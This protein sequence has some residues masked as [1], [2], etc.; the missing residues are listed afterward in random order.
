LVERDTLHRRRLIEQE[1]RHA[2]F[3]HGNRFLHF[4]NLFN[5]HR[6]LN[7]GLWFSGLRARG[8][9]NALDIQVTQNTFSFPHLPPAFDGCRILHLSDLHINGHGRIIDRIIEIISALE[10]DLCVLTGDYRFHLGRHCT[11]TYHKNLSRVCR[12]INSRLG[13][14]A[15]LG[16]HDLLEDVTT[17]TALG[18]TVL[19]NENCGVEDGGDVLWVAGVDDPHYYRCAN[20]PRAL[21]GIPDDVFTLLLAHTPSIYDEAAAAGID[22]YLCGHTH[23]GQIRLPLIGP[24]IRHVHCPHEYQGGLWQHNGM[25]GYTSVGAGSSGVPVRFNC[26]PEVAV[27]TLRRNAA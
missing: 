19:V 11:P 3:H 24:V 14:I 8:E 6:M 4:E 22:L 18:V 21:D 16:N 7:L 2:W 1:F 12:A 15:V 27:H 5:I 23:A 9:R 26:R 17:L 25:W 10:V 13:T 20:L